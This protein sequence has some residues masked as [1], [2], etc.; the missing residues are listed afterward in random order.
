[1]SRTWGG[2]GDT[3]YEGLYGE[4]PPERGLFFRLQ[5][6]ERMGMS[7]VKVYER[8]GKSVIS[9]CERAQKG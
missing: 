8:G 2:G 5:V 3:P 4:T 9:V 7:L 6:Y 1:M